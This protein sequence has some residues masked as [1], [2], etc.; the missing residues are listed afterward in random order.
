MPTPTIPDGRLFF[1]ATTYTGNGYPLTNTQAI[2]NAVNG[3]SMQP[4]FVWIKDRGQ[5]SFHALFDSVRGVTKGLY[6]NTT[7]AEV[8]DASALLS[9]NS[10]G[11]T[12][13][14]NSQTSFDTNNNGYALVG[15][16]WK[17]GGTA[18]TNTAG[19]ITSQVSAN[20]TSGFS[21][22]KYTGQSGGG[23]WGHG[24]GVEP[25][26]IIFK[27]YTA[28]QNW[29]VFTKATGSWRYFEG[30]NNTTASIDYSSSMSASSTT[31]TLPNFAEYTTDPSS[32]YVAYCFSEVAGY[33]K[34]GIYTGNGSTSND[35]PFVYLGF[36][37]RFIM[38]KRSDST[39]G[40]WMFD[41]S[42]STSNLTDDY[43]YANLSDAEFTNITTLNIDILSNGFKIR[44]GS[45]PS[46]FINANGG[47]YIYMAF[48][49]N[50]FKY[51]NAR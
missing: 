41:T 3:V 48:A 47:T 17:A 11:F 46:S 39:G 50:P 18:V 14:N 2:N 21:V 22:V 45:S 13:G 20:T 24:L 36:R 29:F 27:R 10:N 44:S 5:A 12:V 37:P 30:I 38:G 35:G 31:V 1:S 23:S 25:K 8:T 7:S 26:Y 32:N 9:F 6:S 15:W 40:W 49:E 43:F 4:D 42:R 34:F 51:A 28:G 19:T 16:N 33:N